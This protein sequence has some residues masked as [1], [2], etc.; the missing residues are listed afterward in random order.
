MINM[1]VISIINQYYFYSLRD[2]LTHYSSVLV[3]N[4][5]ISNV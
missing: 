3:S 1:K 2:A 4:H 5:D